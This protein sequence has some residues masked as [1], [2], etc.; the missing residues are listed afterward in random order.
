MNDVIDFEQARRKTVEEE[1]GRMRNELREQIV[2]IYHLGGIEALEE[3]VRAG[4][5]AV[6]RMG[7]N[8]VA[9]AWVFITDVRVWLG[10]EAADKL[11]ERLENIV[12]AGCVSQRERYSEEEIDRAEAVYKAA[13][14]GDIHIDRCPPNEKLFVLNSI[15]VYAG[16]KDESVYTVQRQT[17]IGFENGMIAVKNGAP[18]GVAKNAI[19]FLMRYADEIKVRSAFSSSGA[20]IMYEF[21]AVAVEEDR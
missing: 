11:T 2:T 10:D 4:I 18:L 7:K 9:A 19:A 12:G 15:A 6:E 17:P 14:R 3:M 20:A 21:R 8:K 13:L 1:A 16:A 5:E